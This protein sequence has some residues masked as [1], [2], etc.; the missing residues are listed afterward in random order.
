MS[1]LAVPPI[2]RARRV[3]HRAVVEAEISNVTAELQ[4]VL[5][6]ALVAMIVG[7]DVRTV[8]RWTAANATKP[9]T[10]DNQRLR[11]T[12]Q[13]QQLLLTADAPDVVRAWFVG[14][15]PQLNELSP[16]EALA[17]GRARDV[18]AAA[19]AFVNAG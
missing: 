18:M 11:D 6:Q 8:A 16:A 4:K 14:M 17:D 2:D 15:N 5:G 10:R 9:S 1:S 3:T 19:R 13:V 7:K 12:L